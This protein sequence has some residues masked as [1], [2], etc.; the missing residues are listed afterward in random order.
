VRISATPNMLPHFGQGLSFFGFG[1][2]VCFDRMIFAASRSISASLYPAS[3]KRTFF[4]PMREFYRGVHVAATCQQEQ[5]SMLLQHVNRNFEIICDVPGRSGAFV[6]RMSS[7]CLVSRPK[8]ADAWRRGGLLTF[9]FLRSLVVLL[10]AIILQVLRDS[11]RQGLDSKRTGISLTNLIRPHNG[12][13]RGVYQL[14]RH[15]RV[16]VDA[17][18]IDSMHLEIDE[19]NLSDDANAHPRNRR[20]RIGIDG[21]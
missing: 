8:N 9:P 19:L 1:A 5:I 7:R 2:L 16:S 11:F 13:V 10:E 21:V 20:F 15:L 4:F 12:R 6:G 18:A 17:D 14:D 3:L